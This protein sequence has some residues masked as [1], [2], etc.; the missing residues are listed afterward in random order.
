MLRDLE[1]EIA[2]LE[3]PSKITSIFMGGGTP[4]L[5]S[6]QSIERLLTAISKQLTL[7]R[8]VEITLE[9]N[10]G[11]VDYPRFTDF[12][13]AGVN[14]LSM[15]VQSFQDE[16]LKALGRIHAGDEAKRAIDAAIQA[17]F[18]NFN[19]DLMHG[20]PKQT[21]SAAITD[22]ETAI[23][24]SPTHLSWYQLT[25]EPNTYFYRYPPLLPSDE[26]LADIQEAGQIV[27]E[28]AGF[29]QY[30][31]SAY[32]RGKEKQCRHNLNYWQFGDYLA[33]GA[34]A[35]GKATTSEGI[36]RYWKHR[37]PA[38]YL[39]QRESYRA[40]SRVIS[41]NELP[42]EYLLNALR[43][44]EKVLESHFHAATGLKFC[45]IDEKIHAAINKGLLLRDDKS[46]EATKLGYRF[47]NELLTLFLA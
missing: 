1:Q 6:P 47:L 7:D 3:N 34:G 33:I 36:V 32:C 12:F 25:I 23:S 11:T 13:K 45:N 5:F 19:L 22:L 24:F 2:Q 9:A 41:Q 38:S 29:E 28:N 10:P 17:G 43:L 40:E 4:S 37:V 27:L 18:V 35:H 39:K 20:L 26:G 8:D 30:E 16:Q 31:V 15:G 46:I 14:R 21:V 44:K 42:F